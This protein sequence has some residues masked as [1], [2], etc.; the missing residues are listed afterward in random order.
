M[1]TLVLYS[2]TFYEDSQFNKALLE[3][4]SKLEGVVVRNLNA[5]YPESKINIQ[6]EISLLKEAEKIIAQFPLFWFS[7]PSLFK[8]YQDRVLTHIHT[9]D[10]KMLQGKTFR[11]I[12]TAGGI[13]SKYDS[14]GDGEM[15]GI[16]RALFPI[17]KAFEYVGATS[18][19][20]F[21]IYDVRNTALP[22]DA[23]LD[24]VDA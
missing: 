15:S 7:S 17:N 22:F 1:K 23:Y 24:I 21:A 16:A 13:Q 6:K 2:H 20:P 5:I 3:R 18:L 12:T 4:A 9:H 8:E 11:I 10:P 14:W 19:E